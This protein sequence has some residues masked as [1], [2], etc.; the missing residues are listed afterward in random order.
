MEIQ[1]LIKKCQKNNSRAQSALYKLY[2]GKLYA[3]CYKYS[4]NQ[5]EA[6]DNLHDGFITIF[7]KIN[8]FKN[9]GSFEGWMKRIMINTTLEKYRKD[10]VFPLVNEEIKEEIDDEI[11]EKETNLNQLLDSIQKLPNRYRL[12]FNLYVLDGYSHKEIGKLL[13]IS[14]GTSKSNLSRAKVLLKKELSNSNSSPTTKSV[15]L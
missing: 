5:T 10:K 3:V 12:V 8:Q 7:N 4:K 2:A 15:S 13:D 6:E 1:E 11:E 9:Q 14:E